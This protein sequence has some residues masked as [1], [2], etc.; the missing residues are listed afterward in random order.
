MLNKLKNEKFWINLAMISLFWPFFYVIPTE[1]LHGNTNFSKIIG[2]AF[3]LFALGVI[4]Q[5]VLSIIVI[6]VVFFFLKKFKPN[7]FK[8]TS[9]PA[10]PEA[11]ENTKNKKMALGLKLFIIFIATIL[12]FSYGMALLPALF[13]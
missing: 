9:T 5:G 10:E 8:Q 11:A 7:I 3:M 6:K 12:I 4:M 13:R 2:F 1:L